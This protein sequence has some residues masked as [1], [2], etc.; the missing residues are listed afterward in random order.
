V[1]A[2][3]WPE[4]STIDVGLAWIVVGTCVTVIGTLVDSVPLTTVSTT[5]PFPPTELR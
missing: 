5:V 2:W 3:D 4:L 1:I